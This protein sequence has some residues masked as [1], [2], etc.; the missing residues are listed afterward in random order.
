MSLLPDDKNWIS[1]FGLRL[2][3]RRGAPLPQLNATALAQAEA[4]RL[5]NREPPPR[6]ATRRLALAEAARISVEA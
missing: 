1:V 2:R 4:T 5:K 6:V 3:M